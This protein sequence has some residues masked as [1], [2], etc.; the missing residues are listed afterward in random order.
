MILSYREFC[1][2]PPG[3]GFDGQASATDINAVFKRGR[4]LFFP[5][6]IKNAST[7][8][9]TPS[10]MYACMVAEK[11]FFFVSPFRLAN[12]C[13]LKTFILSSPTRVYKTTFLRLPYRGCLLANSAIFWNKRKRLFVVRAGTSGKRIKSVETKIIR[14]IAD[15]L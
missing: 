1:W 10:R 7:F 14:I 4:N 6:L 8:F 12:Y 11:L 5:L 13:K 3:P 15:C 9:S 2:S